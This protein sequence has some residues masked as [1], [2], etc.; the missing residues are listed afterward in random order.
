MSD[1]SKYI[2]ITD[3]S[4]TVL[5]LIS[6]LTSKI[7]MGLKGVSVPMFPFFISRNKIINYAVLSNTLVLKRR[8]KSDYKI[9]F[10]IKDVNNIESAIRRL[11]NNDD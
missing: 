7:H 5:Y 3:F 1:T 2:L 4:I 10:E 8:G 11:Q 6:F 9:A